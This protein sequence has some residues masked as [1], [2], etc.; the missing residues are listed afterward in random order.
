MKLIILYGSQSGNAQDLAERIWRQ[1]KY[2][3]VEET[4]LSSMDQFSLSSETLSD[5]GSLRLLFVCSTTGQGEV[6]DNMT[7]FW[8][9]I[10]RRSVQS[11]IFTSI[12]FSTIGLG[13]SSY[14]KYN[15]IAKKLYKRIIQLGGEAISNLCLC[16]DQNSDGIEGT[17]SRWIKNYWMS[18]FGEEFTH[19]FQKSLKIKNETSLILKYKATI[20]STADT[21]KSSFRS[22]PSEISEDTPLY[23]KLTKNDRVTSDEHWQNTR[24][25]EFDCSGSGIQYEAGDVLMLNPSNFSHTITK[26]YETFEHLNFK[27][28]K[29]HQITIDLNYS[30][31]DELNIPTLLDNKMIS[32]LGDLVE[33]YFDLNSRP[34]MSFFEIFAQLATD[35]LE[36]EKL[37]EFTNADLNG[38]DGLEELYTYCYRPKRTLIEI[39]HDFPKTTKNIKSL[40]VLLEMI[41][42]IK[43]RA[44]SIASSPC[45]HGDKIQILVAVVEYKTRLVETRKGTCSYW[46]STLKPSVEDVRVPIWI[47]KGSFKFNWC[48]PLICVGP[49]TGVAPFRSIINERIVKHNLKDNHLYFGCRSQQADCYFKAEWEKYVHQSSL[50]LNIAFSQAHENKVYVQDLILENSVKIFEL[51]DNED[52]TVLIAGSSNRMPQD[53]MAILTKIIKYNLPNDGSEEDKEKTASDYIKYLEQKKRIQLETWS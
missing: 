26:F 50:D 17:F 19:N 45:V 8:K 30:E 35:E 39:F 40:D 29:N 20:H 32:T 28:R 42:S 25:L 1:A 38:E 7:N 14:E 52:A 13:D 51:L 15:F 53:V 37:E 48:K 33:K 31:K 11:D 3:G 9:F 12:K 2:Y 36:K 22:L 16:D 46:L 23:A 10:M 27:T 4:S 5:S 6:P 21:S 41:P 44:F 49:G 24:L 18:V 47:K 43:P 34:R